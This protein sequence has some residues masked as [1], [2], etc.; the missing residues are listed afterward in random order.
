MLLIDFTSNHTYFFFPD[1]SE[2]FDSQKFK[3][4]E[5]KLA[6]VELVQSAKDR[7]QQVRVLGSGHSRNGLAG[8]RDVIVSLERF[9]GV[10]HLDKEA[11][12]V[13]ICLHVSVLWALL[14]VC[15]WFYSVMQCNA[16]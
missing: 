10:V 2:F 13:K 7:G 1:Y 11:M 6:V 5:T 3:F 14:L 8:S 15:A 4:P 12:Q 9:R 16:M